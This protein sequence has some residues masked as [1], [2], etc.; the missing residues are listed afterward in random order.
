MN[1][2]VKVALE[3]MARK[4]RFN[5]SARQGVLLGEAPRRPLEFIG[6]YCRQENSDRSPRELIGDGD[7]FLTPTDAQEQSDP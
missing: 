3:N 7:R 5:K 6:R 1:R 4:S 2:S